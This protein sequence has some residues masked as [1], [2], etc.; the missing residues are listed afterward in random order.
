MDN[1]LRVDKFLW[2]ARVFKTRSISNNACI[3]G[4]VRINNNK[5]KPS[6]K[7]RVGQVIYV[8]RDMVLNQYTVINLPTSRLS[9]KDVRNYIDDITPES[10]T[11]KYIQAKNQ[12][13]IR[14]SQGK[15]RPT[16]KERRELEKFLK[17]N[18]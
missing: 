7:I 3:S 14:R 15:G 5:V 11:I 13:V 17:K 6:Y 2:M 1:Q 4:K 16:K 10:E 12:P 8:R 18:N 9:P